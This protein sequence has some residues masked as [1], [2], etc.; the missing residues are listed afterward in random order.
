MKEAIGTSLVFTLIMI[1]TG[2]LIV[3]YVGSLSYTKG[4]KVRNKI[5]DI[6]DKNDGYSTA[7]EEEIEKELAAIGYGLNKSDKTCKQKKGHDAIQTS[8]YRYCLYEYTNDTK[9]VY[10]GVTVFI[11][12]DI[13]LIGKFVEIPLYGETKLIFK[14]IE[15]KE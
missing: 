2:V 6:I 11:Q 3:I 1:F 5:I 10:Y 15:I 9:G 14:D 8:D 13:P 12:V 4:F 7:V